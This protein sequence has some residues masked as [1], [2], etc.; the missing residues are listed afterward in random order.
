MSRVYLDNC[1]TTQPDPEVVKVM[2]PYLTEKFYFPGNFIRTG[3]NAR[4][5]IDDCKKII[6]ASLNAESSEINITSGGT[7][8]NNIGIKGYVVGNSH[9]GKHLICSLVDYPDILTH[10]AF[11]E[12]NGYEITYLGANSDGFID[13]EELERSIRTDTILLMTTLA[14]HVLGTIQPIN[15][16]KEIINRK[17]PQCAL[18]IDAGH[19]YG[20]M[21]IDVKNFDCDLLTFSAHKINGP[22]GAGAL[23]IKKGTIISQ[24]KHGIARI[25]ELETGGISLAAI[26]GMAKAIEIQFQS[27][28]LYIEQ[29]LTL[30]NRLLAGIEAKIGRVFLNGP[31]DEN[32]ICHN[33]NISIEDVEGEGLMLMLDLAGI[34][35]NTGSACASQGLKPNYV[36]MA[37][38][39]SFTQSHG[40]IKFTLSRMTTE[41]EIDYVIDKFSEQVLK[42]RR[43]SPLPSKGDRSS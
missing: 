25:D 40:S 5:D 16:I 8:A 21:P 22:Q 37:T 27:L 24:T 2:L 3:S 17:N 13:L 20:R 12:T 34:T 1:L 39:R 41:S 19:A 23:Y 38:G 11:Y 18:F 14:N 31:L 7:S 28:N 33:L 43:I 30:R 9:H 10:A 29:M 42:L 36:L 26:A 15:K 6:A 4:K 32:R 35:V